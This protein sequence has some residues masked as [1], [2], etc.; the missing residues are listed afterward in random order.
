[1]SFCTVGLPDSTDFLCDVDTHRTPRDAASATHT[2]RGLK[3]IDPGR[4]FMRHPLAVARESRGTHGTSVDIRMRRSETGVP[5][6]PALRMV[7]RKIRYF[8]DSAAEAR[9]ANH[10]AVR[11]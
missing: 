1:M 11:A 9:R 7:A 2:A 5:P 6:P 3:L 8:F 10:C 4:E